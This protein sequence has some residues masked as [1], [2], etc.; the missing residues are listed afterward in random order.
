[1]KFPKSFPE[2]VHLSFTTVLI[3]FTVALLV[4]LVGVVL[5]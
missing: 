2:F 5:F 4:V 1:M 3:G